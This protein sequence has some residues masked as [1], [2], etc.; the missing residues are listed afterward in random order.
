LKFSTPLFFFL[1]ILQ[2]DAEYEGVVKSTTDFGVF[3]DLGMSTDGLIHKSQLSNT[4]VANV[5]DLGLE[6][7]QT[8]KVRVLSVDAAKGQVS[9][10]MKDKGE[11]SAKPAGERKRADLSK[12]EAMSPQEEVD[13]TVDSIMPYGAFVK[14]E[15]GVQGLVHISQLSVGRVENTGDAVSVSSSSVGAGVMGL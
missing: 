6:K 2:V 5:A 10:S 8:V 14:F 4:F 9:L 12:Y 7:G 13:A 3:V 11:A 1:L 15:D